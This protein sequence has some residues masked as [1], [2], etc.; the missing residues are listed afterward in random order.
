MQTSPQHIQIPRNANLHSCRLKGPKG[1][2]SFVK[3]KHV[4]FNEFDCQALFLW[5]KSSLHT[6]HISKWQYHI[7]ANYLSFI[8]NKLRLGPIKNPYTVY[9]HNQNHNIPVTSNDTLTF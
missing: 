1:A 4:D 2:W 9:K 5:K 6:K 3:L 8:L 7:P